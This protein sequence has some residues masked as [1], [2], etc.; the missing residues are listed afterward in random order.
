MA[1]PRIAVV[2]TGSW[3]LSHVRTFAAEPDAALTWVCDRDP[4]ALARAARLAPGAR[5]T[6][7]LDEVL[8]AP[9]STAW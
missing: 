2:G 9:T 4:A 6:T 3:G 7:D 8:A 1:R 5:A